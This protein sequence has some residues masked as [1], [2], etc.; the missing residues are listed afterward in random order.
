ML[1][2]I[3]LALILLH[4]FT[5]IFSFEDGKE[6][7][8]LAIVGESKSAVISSYCEALDEFDICKYFKYDKK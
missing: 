4:I 2:N 3:F 5:I 1:S 6:E 8:N 7:I